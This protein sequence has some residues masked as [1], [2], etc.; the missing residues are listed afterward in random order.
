[1]RFHRTPGCRAERAPSGSRTRTSAM[2]RRQAGRYIMGACVTCQVVK[3]QEHRVGVE[4]TSPRYEGGIF[5][6]RRA[7]LKNGQCLS[8]GPVGIEPTSPGLRDRMHYPV[9]HSPINLAPAE[10]IEPPI[11][12]LTGRSHTVWPRRIMSVRTAGLEPAISWPPTTRDTRLRHAL[13]VVNDPGGHGSIA[14]CSA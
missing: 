12:G 7:V 4:P 11:I 3:D 10:G 14:T 8:V 1:M 5:A 9:C 13:S 6:A 2:A